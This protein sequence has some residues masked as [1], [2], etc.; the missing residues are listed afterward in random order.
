LKG[1]DK[2]S[3]LLSL[4]EQSTKAL[5]QFV[6]N[7]KKVTPQCVYAYASL[8]FKDDEG[9]PIIPAEHH[10]VWTEL[11]CNETIKKLLII[12]PPDSAKTSWAM[13]YLGC[14]IGKNPDKN[15][16]VG[17]VTDDVAEKR[18]L[19]LRNTIESQIWKEMFP[20]VMRNEQMKWEQSEWSIKSIKSSPT[21]KLHPTVRSYGTNSSSIIGSRADFLLGDDLLS[22][23]N[24]ATQGQRVKFEDWMDQQF[25]TRRKP[26]GRTIL[27]G[28]AYNAADYYAKIRRNPM[29]W[30][31]CICQSYQENGFNI[32]IYYPDDWKGVMLGESMEAANVPNS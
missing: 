7:E 3:Q 4:T 28:T 20:D 2:Q 29:G 21:G 31:I 5:I 17:A 26:K 23:E 27:I 19:S 12:S 22:K 30:V 11:F 6:R 32:D 10:K 25:L 8:I 18:S 13:A 15:Y 1:L 24:T 16:I 14:L 9:L